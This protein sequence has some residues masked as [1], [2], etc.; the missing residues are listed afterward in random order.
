MTTSGKV[1]EDAASPPPS[2]AA[3][4]AEIAADH[5]RRSIEAAPIGIICVDGAK[6]RYVFA[7]KKFADMI[8]WPHAELVDADPFQISI[9][10]TH[11]DDRA[12]SHQAMVAIAQGLSDTGHYE[13]RLLRRDGGLLWVAVD[14]FA[15][16]D[17]EGRLAFLTLYFTD[18]EARRSADTT[19]EQLQGQLRQSQKLE[20]LGRLAGGIAH[21]F[22]NRLLIIMGHT[23]MLKSG[24]PTRSP[25]RTRTDLVLGSAQ[26]ASELTRQLLAYSRRQVLKPQAFDI[27]AVVENM[28]RVLDSMVGN[29]IEVITLLNARQAIMA[30]PGQVEQ[31]II[32]LAINARDAM[33]RGGRLMIETRDVTGA[34]PEGAQQP[35][36][37]H[38]AL[39]VR[40]TG[41]GISADV[42]PRIFE[43]FFTTKEV[44]RGTGLGLA[45]VEGIVQQS[46]GSVQVE[47]EPGR[48]SVFTILLPR[49]AQLSVIGPKP[50]PAEPVPAAVGRDSSFETVLVCDD[51][52]GVRELIANVLR[53]RGYTVLEAHDGK[54]ALE[55]AARQ[56]FTI[57]L[58]VTDLVMPELGGI[59]LAA[60]LRAQVPTLRVL[61]ISGFTEQTGYLSGPLEP[62]THFMPKPFLPS[63]LTSA[64]SA[65]LENGARSQ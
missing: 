34:Q 36:E 45:T 30:D 33:P 60:Q 12:K 8:G 55:V 13:K 1:A 53:L 47:S 5:Y 54:Q 29:G 44:G 4:E 41:E 43:P 57:H 40:D 9:D 50:A 17:A 27:N 39:V 2:S 59:E 38:V 26:R 32:N 28:R 65:I 62:G 37:R 14:L 20:A 48:G 6:G 64:V 3:A 24:L 16:R 7:N 61:Y 19:L 56:R 11:P 25:L 51:N 35:D 42:L 46:G 49:A 58:L 15:R 63:D 22:N 52:Q 23:E 10:A 21:D 31:V 18:I